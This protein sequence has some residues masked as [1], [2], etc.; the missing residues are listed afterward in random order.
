MSMELTRKQLEQLLADEDNKVVALSG[1]W[2][3]GKSFMWGQVQKES[4]NKKVTGALYV[5]LF[6]LSSIEQIKIKLIQSAVPL[7]ESNPTLL[8]GA[9]Q[10]VKS[11]VKVLE[12]LH[13]SFGALNDVSLLLAPTLLRQKLIVL[14]DIERKH[15]N[16]NIDEIL[17]FIDE[18]TQRFE[19]RFLLILN[20][21]RLKNREVWDV[22][23][24]KVVD[25]E[26]RLTTTC[27]EAFH[28]AIALMPSHFSAAISA[29]IEACGVTN[30]RIIIKV[31]KAVNR[32]VGERK[33]IADAVLQRVISSTVLLAAIHYKP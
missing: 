6:G 20:S 15:D 2:G 17:G 8:D 10:L 19:C 30:I 28:V 23:R 26:I 31:I 21:D 24:E 27:D 4:Q 18:F 33:C 32:V 9:K 7:L 11:S 12:G 1:K 3:T 29:A 5:S 25:E 14:D 13:K 16:L 22:L